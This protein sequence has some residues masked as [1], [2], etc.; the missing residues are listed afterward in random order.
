MPVSLVQRGPFSY[1]ELTVTATQANES[2]G[3]HQRDFTLTNAIF[4]STIG[5]VLEVFVNGVKLVGS[6]LNATGDEFTVD[7]NV[8]K[9][10]IVS[11]SALNTASDSAVTTLAENDTVLIRRVSNRTAKKVDFAPGS[12]IREA[13]LDNANTQVFHTA[14]EAI[15]IAL[16]GMVLDTD[17]RWNGASGN[18]NRN[19]KNVATPGAS[20]PDDYV[21]TKGY[22]DSTL[23]STAAARDASLDHRDTAEDY[24]L[25]SGAVVRHF[26]GASN[27]TSDTSPSDQAGV[28]SAKKHAVGTTVTTGSAKAWASNPGS[29]QVGSTDY[30]AKAWASDDGNNI[31]SSKDWASKAGS[32]QVASTDFSSK[33]YAQDDANDIGSAKD[34]ASKATTVVNSTAFYS[35]KEY[36]SGDATASGGSAKAWATDT[37]SPDNTSTKSA[38]TWAGEAATSAST[39]ESSA[40]VMGIA[41]G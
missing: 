34:W 25:R 17:S 4:D 6:G 30:S 28:F 24:A 1:D 2:A 8:S 16:Q 37:L 15:D 23:N 39:S 12:V 18:A 35:A 40:I 14:Q 13:D 20:D 41:L 22:A 5:E 21:A 3:G 32:A 26:S 9:I 31:G 27:N 29:A 38:K 7:G 36:A 11:N 10:T 19:I 33:A